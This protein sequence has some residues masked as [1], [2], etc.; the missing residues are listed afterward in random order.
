MHQPRRGSLLRLLHDRRSAAGGALRASKLLGA[1]GRAA[2]VAAVAVLPL[3][4]ALGASALHEAVGEEHLAVLA[5][6]L[7][8]RLLRY[9]ARLLHRREELLGE[10]L[11][12]GRVRRVVVV[13]G[14]LE[15]GEVLEVY[16]VR[17][18]D[19]VLGRDSLLAGADHHGRAVRVVRADVDALVPAQLLEAHP[20]VGLDVFH[21]VPEVDVTV[22]VRKR[23]RNDYASLL[24]RH[25]WS[26]ALK[27]RPYFV[28]VRSLYSPV[29]V[30]M[31]I[32]S[33]SLMKSGTASV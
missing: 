4:A 15:V 30:L 16:R 6:E 23:A 33:P 3:R 17:A 11:V 28:E 9:P 14:D 20:E 24:F 25:G 7:G 31:R 27:R 13:E 8:R 19:E 12:L 26:P 21:Q 1:V 22:R 18:R 2:L 29:S 32:T 10:R 5:V